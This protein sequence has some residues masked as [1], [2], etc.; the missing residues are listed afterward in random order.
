MPKISNEDFAAI[1]EGLRGL[2]P[3]P[4]VNA[5][6]SIDPKQIVVV[7]RHRAALDPDRSLVIGNRGVG[8]SFWTQVLADPQARAV[9]AKSFGELATVDVTIGFNN[10]TRA[11]AVAPTKRVINQVFAASSDAEALWD[12]VLLR[13]ARF[14]GVVVPDS[15]PR[16]DLASEVAWV[17][18]N[19]ESVDRILTALDDQCTRK[20]KKLIL[21]FD[22]L[23]QLGTD[24]A[25]KR[26]LTTGLLKRAFD[27]RSYHSLRL[28]LFM[29][30][31]QFEDPQI[32]KFPDAS[33]LANARVDLLWNPTEL[34]TLLF[35]W[36]ASVQPSLEAFSRLQT[37]LRVSAKRGTDDDHKALV[38]AIAGEFMGATKK[39]GRVFSWLPLH[40]SDARAET[41]PRTFLTAWREAALTEPAPPRRAVDHR[42]LHAGVRKASSAR[43]A[44]L[45][46][47]YNW[48][49]LALNPL[50]KQL[51]P[52]ERAALIRLWKNNATAEKIL[53][54]S[55]ARNEES[56]QLPP[57]LLDGAH[58]SKGD[59]EEALIKD[60]AA[61][62]IVE[63]RPNGKI[64]IPDIF[65][66]E[67][68]IGR[69]GGVQ[70]R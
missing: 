23:D 11:E 32:L 53:S 29:R 4:S 6:T 36:L 20:K 16:D 38:D 44:E 31:D 9:V 43:V 18:A 56:A 64:N 8:K 46:Q 1:R 51:V 19:G 50:R 14:H 66:L 58:T 3:D 52:I 57:V 67:F 42:G 27:A 62:G 54:E 59:L 15:L 41:S 70:R 17:Q 65:R 45:E 61:I 2:D 60:L 26:T 24:W 48:I 13:A 22:A 30:R 40:L 33:K 12:A 55:R 28:K 68:E 63:E 10:P 39:R 69:K 25:S 49:P 34:Y 37:T 7:Q 35:Q 5:S 47:D 21:V